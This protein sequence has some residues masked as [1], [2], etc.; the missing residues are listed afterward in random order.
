MKEQ[1]IYKLLADGECV[2]LE[3]KKAQ[4]GVPSSLWETYSAFANTYG[5]TI[6]LGVDENMVGEGQAK[7]FVI[8]GVGEADRMRKDL[9]NTINS[10]E[11]VS[12][13]LLRDEDVQVVSV[14]GKNVI[15]I[16]VPRA[17]Y[18]IRPVYINNN[19]SRGTYKRNHEG[20]YHCTEQELRMMVRDSNETGN[21]RMFLEYY[22]MDDID[23]PSLERY[24]MLFRTDHPEHVWNS[25]EHKEF[26]VQIGGY[27]VNRKEQTEGLTMAGL[28]MFGKGLP[29]RDRFDN[30]RMDYIDKTNLIGEQRYSDRLT[31]DGTWENNLFNFIQNVLPKL[32]KD[33]PRPFR[34]EG[35]I[36]KDD[37]PQHK[38]VREALTN[39]IIHA[40]LML[41][42]VLKV[43]KYDDRFVLTNPGLLKL[44]VEQIYAG[45]ESRA[46]NQRMQAML[47]AIGYGENLGSGFPL[48]LSAWNEKHWLKPEL[49]EQPELMQVKLILHIETLVEEKPNDM[50]DVLKNVLKNV[51][52]DVLK[53]LTDRQKS[54]LE[55]I[56]CT[57]T[58]TG[59]EMSERLRVSEKTVQRDFSAIRK[60]GINLIREG[61]KTYGHW[62]IKEQQGGE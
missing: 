36:R 25:L 47:R 20:D 60:L 26:L 62:I 23:I 44:P 12:I 19:L 7:R 33:L 43:E 48:I 52:K 14:E 59:Q 38:A 53:E 30:L 5:G 45:G 35:V 22:T 58:M 17:D 54:I 55:F 2:T 15:V 29:V 18:T 9:W 51:S 61:G 39:A 57:P 40:D 32:T 50:S 10:H 27:V 24:R 8:T 28:L 42:G 31:Y 21:D 1:Y 37:T 4:K 16:N 41:N 3:C 49:I 46:R 34:M 6:L 11:K 56:Y 13:N